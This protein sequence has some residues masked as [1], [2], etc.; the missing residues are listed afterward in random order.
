[1]KLYTASALFST[2][3]NMTSFKTEFL[4]QWQSFISSQ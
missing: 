3:L 1:V 2:N 4:D